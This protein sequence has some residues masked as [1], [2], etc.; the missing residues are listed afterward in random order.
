MV[1]EARGAR[2]LQWAIRRIVDS[3]PDVA[4]G[5]NGKEARVFWVEV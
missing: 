5:P 4:A 1:D 2:G 3:L